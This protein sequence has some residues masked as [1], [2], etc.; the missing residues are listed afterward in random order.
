[1]QCQNTGKDNEGLALQPLHWKSS[2][3]LIPVTLWDTLPSSHMHCHMSALGSLCSWIYCLRRVSTGRVAPVSHHAVNNF[4][5]WSQQMV[6]CLL[7]PS[8]VVITSPY[9]NPTHHNFSAPS[10]CHHAPAAWLW[11][12]W[13]V[14]LWPRPFCPWCHGTGCCTP[15]P[16]APH[17][18]RS[19]NQTLKK[20]KNRRVI[21]GDS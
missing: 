14:P 10:S 2:Y 17:S 20:R 16:L 13:S 11:L 5:F 19:Q 8:A 7:I 4:F 1:M 15:S 18:Q 12:P 3:N 9:R 21:R 6:C